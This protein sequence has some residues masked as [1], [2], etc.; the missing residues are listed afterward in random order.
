VNTAIVDSTRNRPEWAAPRGTV[1]PTPM[2]EFV[3]AY[4]ADQIRSGMAPENVAEMV[5]DAILTDTFWIFTD[6]QMVA[7]LEPR[8]QSVLTAT[9][10]P[11]RDFGA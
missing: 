8:H 7:S 5:L 4:V 9:N 2:E 6:M 1:E 10:P 3:R 11:D